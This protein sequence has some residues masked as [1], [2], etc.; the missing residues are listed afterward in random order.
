MP[1]PSR[2]QTDTFR[3]PDSCEIDPNHSGDMATFLFFKMAAV[4][5]LGFLKI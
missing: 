5:N 4:G 1:G 3:V 2:H